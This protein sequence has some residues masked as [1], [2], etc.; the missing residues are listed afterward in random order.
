WATDAKAC[1]EL[2]LDLINTAIVW[3]A[4]TTEGKTIFGGA[5]AH[6]LPVAERR[7]IAARLMPEIRGRIGKQARKLDHFYDQDAV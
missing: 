1:Y 4:E 6:S 7:A 2:T 5:L 3:F